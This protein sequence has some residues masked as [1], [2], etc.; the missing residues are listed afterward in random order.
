MKAFIRGLHYEEARRTN[1]VP[2]A[3]TDDPTPQRARKE[4]S[5]AELIFL[6]KALMKN[7][8]GS[9]KTMLRKKEVF[10]MKRFASL[11]LALVL[12]LVL[13][14]PAFAMEANTVTEEVYDLGNGI[15]IT[16]GVGGEVP[17]MSSREMYG[18]TTTDACRVQTYNMT[19]SEGNVCMGYIHNRDGLNSG[20][21]VDFEVKVNGEIVN[22]PT[23]TAISQPAYVKV[24][25]NTGSGLNGY[26]RAVISPLNGGNVNYSYNF[27]QSWN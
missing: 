2:E 26:V 16:V 18:T 21:K 6:Y 9:T 10:F 25:S 19:A 15:T 27:N 13:A 1:T 12:S 14:V 5:N 23:Q 17:P 22:M 8:A 24:E 11:I 3:E 7:E 4:Q 20:V